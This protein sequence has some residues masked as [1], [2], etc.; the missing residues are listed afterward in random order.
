MLE[1]FIQ[2]GIMPYIYINYI[3]PFWGFVNRQ[4]FNRLK[5]RPYA[6]VFGHECGNRQYTASTFTRRRSASASDAS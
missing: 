2:S 6:K 3:N 5:G 4:I 1:W